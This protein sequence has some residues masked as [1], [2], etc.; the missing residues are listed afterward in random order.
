MKSS[1]AVCYEFEPPTLREKLQRC[2]R[3]CVTAT[4]LHRN[5]YLG[6]AVVGHTAPGKLPYVYRTDDRL[7]PLVPLVPFQ[8]SPDDDV[9]IDNGNRHHSPS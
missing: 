3:R 1:R 7:P 4:R 2:K 9:R 5:K 8:P 6:E